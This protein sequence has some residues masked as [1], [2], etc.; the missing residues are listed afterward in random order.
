MTHHCLRVVFISPL[1]A[2]VEFKMASGIDPVGVICFVAAGLLFFMGFMGA[3]G[4]P[5][6]MIRDEAIVISLSVIGFLGCAVLSVVA[7]IRL[8]NANNPHPMGNKAALVAEAAPSG[9]MQGV[10]QG[11]GAPLPPRL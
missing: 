2:T 5:T 6:G 9:P 4:Q 3:M 7:A 1:C 10:F 11:A 8:A